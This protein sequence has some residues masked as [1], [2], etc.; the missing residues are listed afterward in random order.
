MRTTAVQQDAWDDAFDS[1]DR[2]LTVQRPRGDR[3]NVSATVKFLQEKYSRLPVL[4]TSAGYP[5]RR[6]LRLLIALR[7]LLL[8]C[9][10]RPN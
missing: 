3:T 1:G 6:H 7:W 8:C 5:S 4:G 10:H 2:Q 9:L